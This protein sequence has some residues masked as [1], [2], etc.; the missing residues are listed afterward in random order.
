M[1]N[2]E[3]ALLRLK[4]QIARC[5]CPALLVDQEGRIRFRN[6]SGA[7]LVPRQRTLLPLL[8]KEKSP[9][10]SLI[11]R[12]VSDAV[13][14]IWIAPLQ[15]GLRKVIFL[16][17]LTEREILLFHS[18]FA[19][20]T[21]TEAAADFF[22]SFFADGSPRADNEPVDLLALVKN[23]SRRLPVEIQLNAPGLTEL[24]TVPEIR[25]MLFGVG[26]SAR[27]LCGAEVLTLSVKPGKG[28]AA[29]TFSFADPVGLADE[30]LRLLFAD[31]EPDPTRST[32]FLPLLSV[33]RCCQRRCY[34]LSL[35]RS[36]QTSSLK[37]DLPAATD[38]PAYYFQARG[39]R[40]LPSLF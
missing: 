13:M 12:Q 37:L 4:Q 18:L 21:A 8:A 27:L 39:R 29:V 25:Q 1:D 33:F 28:H 2:K 7:K 30:I 6:R 31:T 15:N 36:G 10:A 38:L 19:Q 26:R 11:L 35:E 22:A 32:A 9:G 24:W 3:A 34:G 5:S 16:R 40:R 23:P 14:L 17:D 20:K